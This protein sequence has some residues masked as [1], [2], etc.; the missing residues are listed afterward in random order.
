MPRVSSFRLSVRMFVRLFVRDSAPFV[1]LLYV[2]VTQGGY[3]SLTTHQ[4]AI[5]FG[6]KVPWRV[7]FQSMTTDPRFMPRGGAR[8]QNLGHF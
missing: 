1:E 4:K 5:L 7:D 2:K 8:G 3:I 6:P